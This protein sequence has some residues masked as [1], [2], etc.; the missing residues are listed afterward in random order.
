MSPD[1]WFQ[2]SNKLADKMT[3]IVILSANWTFQINDI[4]YLAYPYAI[5]RIT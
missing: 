4:S 5:G 3:R 1:F 2:K